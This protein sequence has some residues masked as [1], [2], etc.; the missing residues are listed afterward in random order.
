MV[1]LSKYRNAKITDTRNEK[2]PEANRVGDT[3][4]NV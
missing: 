4:R 2:N 1:S 3:I